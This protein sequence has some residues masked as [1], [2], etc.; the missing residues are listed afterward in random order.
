M[1]ILKRLVM[2]I[3]MYIPFG[4]LCSVKTKGGLTATLYKTGWVVISDGKSKDMLP[5]AFISPELQQKL[6]D[7]IVELG[8]PA[9]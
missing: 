8:Y 6:D 2:T 5:F 9:D 4:K 3:W 7:R 1:K